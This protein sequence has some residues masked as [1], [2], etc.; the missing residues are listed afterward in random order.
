MTGD[1]A[2]LNWRKIAFYDMEIGAA[3]ATCDDLEQHIPGSY[4]RSR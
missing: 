4:L 2:P 3:D 1:N